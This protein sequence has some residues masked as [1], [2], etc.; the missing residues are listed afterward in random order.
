MWLVSNGLGT[1]ELMNCCSEPGDI[2]TCVSLLDVIREADVIWK[3]LH[4]PSKHLVM[5]SNS[6]QGRVTLSPT[7]GM[8]SMGAFLPG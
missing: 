3:Q 2:I 4:I 1:L 7:K 6:K 5:L 8:V